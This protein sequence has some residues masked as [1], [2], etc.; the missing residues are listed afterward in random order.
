MRTS[1]LSARRLTQKFRPQIRKGCGIDA[2]QVV[3]LRKADGARGSSVVIRSNNSAKRLYG[4]NVISRRDQSGAIVGDPEHMEMGPVAI[5]L[6]RS[7]ETTRPGR[8]DFG[9]IK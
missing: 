6:R 1:Y 7:P 4:R 2:P 5:G 9:E 3:L 8:A